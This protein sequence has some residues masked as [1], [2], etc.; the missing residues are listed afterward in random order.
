M[1][2]L[3][4]NESTYFESNLE[5]PSKPSQNIEFQKPKQIF[6]VNSEPD[7]PSGDAGT[8]LP[9][10]PLPP[11]P[12][13]QP[14]KK[15]I[16]VLKKIEQKKCKTKNKVVKSLHILDFDAIFRNIILQQK[17]KII[18]KSNNKKSI[19][20]NNKSVNRLNLVGIKR[21]RPNQNKTNSIQ[22]KFFIKLLFY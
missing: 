7:I 21:V 22:S 20:K 4:T 2:N 6:L 1:K 8:S 13:L 11:L 18:K 3:S 17:K 12:D 14:K 19:K 10:P 16:Q 9:L 15:K 5:S